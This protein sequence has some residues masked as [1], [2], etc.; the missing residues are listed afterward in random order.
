MKLRTTL[1]VA[2]LSLLLT[3]GCV[4]DRVEPPGLT[5]AP[6]A[7]TP[8]PTPS[9]TP[10]PDGITIGSDPALGIVFDDVP[11]L[12]GVEA[13]VYDTVALYETAYWSTMT[14]NEVS[15]L[16]DVIAAPEVK[17]MMGQI[18]TTN[19][20]IS[21]DISGTYR[22]QITSVTVGDDGTAEAILCTDFSSVI[23]ADPNGTYPPEEVGYGERRRSVYTLQD[24]DTH[25]QVTTDVRD[26]TC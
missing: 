26:G 12:T 25:W 18:A 10:D 20:G 5:A 15:P 9:P 22:V 2:T 4:A 19:A 6:T 11:D 3:A 7:S 1:P 24:L 21:A 23:F 17:T 13:D 8:T 14:T 16:F